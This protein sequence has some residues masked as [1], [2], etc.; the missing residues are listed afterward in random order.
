MTR[1]GPHLACGVLLQALLALWLLLAGSGVHAHAMLVQSQPSDGAVL[2]DA[3]AQ[4]TLRFS[5]SVVLTRLRL[6]APGQGFDL[7]LPEAQGA[8]VAVPLPALDAGVHALSWR[9]V[10][11]DGHP[12]AGTVSFAVGQAMQPVP[13]AEIGTAPALA[14]AIW[15]AKVALYLGLLAGVGGVFFRCWIVAAHPGAVLRAVDAALLLGLLAAALSPGLQ[16]ADLMGAGLVASTSAK[17]WRLGASTSLG[18]SLAVAAC[19]MALALAANR[20][21]QVRAARLA[22]LLALAGVGLALAAT[23]HASQAP[24]QWL[25]RLAVFLHGVCA[26]LWLGALLPLAAAL[27]ARDGAV[28]GRQALARFSRVIV[29]PLVALLLAGVVLASVQLRQPGDLLATAY[30]R[31]LAAKLVLVALALALAACNRWRLTVPALQGQD[32]ATQALRRSIAVEAVV[33]VAVLGLVASWRFTPP[34]RALVEALPPAIHLQLQ[35]ADAVAALT[36]APGRAGPVSIIA[37]LVDAAGQPLAAQEVAFTLS[38]AAAGIAP[39][40]AQ[41]RQVGAALWRVD[42][43]LL[44]SPGAW[45]VRVAVLRDAFTQVVLEGTLQL[46]PD[47]ISISTDYFV[48]FACR[49]AALPALH[50]R[51]LDRYRNGMMR[52][53]GDFARAV[54]AS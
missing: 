7:P 22:S 52:G 40:H 26:A 49:A 12:V 13:V 35:S 41:A 44:A 25:T 46:A 54:R 53:G 14:G 4:V 6:I 29:L 16:G 51:V 31:V 28:D 8:T 50:L 2:A 30:G 39:Q 27:R 24:P 11:G 19:A 48:G 10:S 34:P 43:V 33:L 47:S 32:G 42:Q 45:T 15:G 18:V 38:N 5:E 20:M 17:A 9:A 37:S 36:V 3:P 21:Q 23:G 1:L